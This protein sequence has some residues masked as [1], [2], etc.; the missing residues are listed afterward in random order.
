MR[1]PG[2]TLDTGALIAFEKSKREVMALLEHAWQA[3][4]T[5]HVPT[6]V[7]AETW[8]DGK[9]SARLA[10]L[11]AACRVDP[12][13]EDVARLAGEALGSVRAAAT[14]DAIVVASAH[15][16]GAPVVTSD[17]GDL[18]ALA[19]YFGGLPLISI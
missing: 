8:R 12:L 17:P 13:V 7:V 6:V 2:L 19:D 5:L 4:I 14:I 3:G 1:S 16:I 15:A 18:R 11:L 9:R 10:K